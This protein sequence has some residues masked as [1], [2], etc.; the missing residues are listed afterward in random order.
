MGMEIIEMCIRDR[1]RCFRRKNRKQKTH[2]KYAQKQQTNPGKDGIMS[3][4]NIMRQC[5]VTSK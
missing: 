4:D 3:P 5:V 2:M 1:C